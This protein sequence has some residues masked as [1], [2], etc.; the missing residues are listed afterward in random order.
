MNRALVVATLGVACLCVLLVVGCAGEEE[1]TAATR[2]AAVPQSTPASPQPGSPTPGATPT[3]T[4]T[5][6]GSRGEAVET[7]AN[8]DVRQVTWEDGTTYEETIPELVFRTAGKPDAGH[9]HRVVA[10]WLGDD[11]WQ[12][13]IF[14]RVVDYSTEPA[15]TTDLVAEFYYD[16]NKAEFTPAN[17]RAL[18]ALTGRNLC[19]S[20]QSEPDYCPLDKEVGP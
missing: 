17:G 6:I 10:R 19:A 11:S 20:G 14:M 3:V 12:V 15:A 16:E 5:G 4:A 1:N 9:G 2:T 8:S 18:F 7:L 13:S